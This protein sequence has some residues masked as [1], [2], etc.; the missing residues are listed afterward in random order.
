MEGKPVSTSLST[1]TS[2]VFW[3]FRVSITNSESWDGLE[4]EFVILVSL[5]RRPSVSS[6]R[7]SENARGS[8]ARPAST[9]HQS[10]LRGGP[11]VGFRN[12]EIDDFDREVGIFSTQISR[13]VGSP[14]D[15]TWN[16]A[17]RNAGATFPDATPKKPGSPKYAGKNL[18]HQ[19]GSHFRHFFPKSMDLMGEDRNLR[20]RLLHGG[21]L[22]DPFPEPIPEECCDFGKSEGWGL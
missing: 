20:G 6:T 4:S 12:V 21:K 11:E 18:T 19:N 16:P 10:V 8:G 2:C 5:S 1:Y 22:M 17:N 14:S 9:A 13:S 15:G 7:C 3:Y